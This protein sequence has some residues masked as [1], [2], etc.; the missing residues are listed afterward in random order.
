[1]ERLTAELSIG[2]FQFLKMPPTRFFT[3]PA[4]NTPNLFEFDYFPDNGVGQ[5][6]IVAT[7]TDTNV[8]SRTKRIFILS[9]T[10]SR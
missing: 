6:A 3:G 9:M 2:L 7:L 10:T 5:P 8:N 4:A 1:M